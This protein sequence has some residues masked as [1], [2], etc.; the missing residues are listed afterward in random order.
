M[1]LALR[2]KGESQVKDREG[3]ESARFPFHLLTTTTTTFIYTFLLWALH[4]ILI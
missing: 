3:G 1:V 4:F 2:D